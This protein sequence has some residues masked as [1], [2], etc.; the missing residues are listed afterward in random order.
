MV[1]PRIAAW[2][3][4]TVG[5]TTSDVYVDV[6]N[7]AGSEGWVL[8]AVTGNAIAYLDR[9]AGEAWAA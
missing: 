2:L 6:R 5:S 3:W 1:N 8:V 7:Q 4:K 9:P